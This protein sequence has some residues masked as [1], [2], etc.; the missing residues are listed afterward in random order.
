MY[1]TVNHTRFD[2][3]IGTY[4]IA[5]SYIISLYND[6]NNP[7][8]RQL[9][10]EEDIEAVLLAALLHDLGQYPCAHDIEEVDLGIFS[11]VEFTKEL[12]RN[13]NI[14]DNSGRTLKEI[15]EKYWKPT[16]RTSW[17]KLPQNLIL[18]WLYTASSQKST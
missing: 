16:F 12:L 5:C 8:F 6:P 7:L 11:H 4:S 3:S 17:Y 9:V 14:V 13:E 2:H 18:Y 15:I 10:N 1:P